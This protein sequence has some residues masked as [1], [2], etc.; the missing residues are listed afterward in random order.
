MGSKRLDV[1][2]EVKLGAVRL[3]REPQHVVCAGT[4]FTQYVEG[5]AQRSVRN[6]SGLRVHWCQHWCQLRAAELALAS[7]LEMDALR[8]NPSR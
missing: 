6:V 2:V 1:V 3:Q 5:W 8:G 7:L 4:A